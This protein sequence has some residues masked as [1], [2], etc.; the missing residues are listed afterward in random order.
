MKHIQAFLFLVVLVVAQASTQNVGIGTTNPQAR[1]HIA[2]TN[3]VLRLDGNGS[4]NIYH[5]PLSSFT[6]LHNITGHAILENTNSNGGILIRP[7]Y[8]GEGSK[9]VVI[10]NVGILIAPRDINEPN[11]LLFPTAPLD[12]R[13]NGEVARIA[14]TDPYISIFSQGV[15]RGHIRGHTGG[16]TLG[17]LSADVN[18]STNGINRLSVKNNGALA[19]AGNAGSAGQVLTSSGPGGSPYWGSPGSVIYNSFR[20]F[21]QTTLAAIPRSATSPSATWYDIPGL[22]YSFT[23]GSPH[24][25]DVSAHVGVNNC[26][27]CPKGNC[28]LALYVDGNG[29]AINSTYD[30]D[31]N[32]VRYLTINTGFIL[33]AG[34]H[35]IQ[36]RMKCWGG[37]SSDVFY[38]MT[39][40][41]SFHPTYMKVW[42]VPQ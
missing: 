39:T 4:I 25:V 40:S 28:E 37:G 20:F 34:N 11:P 23:L 36:C 42:M 22:Q 3:P 7:G 19:I 32:Q 33:P 26:L 10:N 35:T 27:N 38:I 6:S 14:G 8:A 30:V 24:Y 21:T 9:E 17:S 15:Q 5:S 31:N 2:G 41:G 13:A 18:I 16:L 12:I 1:L 29:F